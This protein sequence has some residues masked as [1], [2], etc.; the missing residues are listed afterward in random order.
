MAQNVVVDVHDF[1]G[2]LGDPTAA[3]ERYVDRNCKQLSSANVQV[4]ACRR[5]V[6]RLLF[7]PS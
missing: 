4:R 6:F 1:F 2:G 3:S 5:L 7:S